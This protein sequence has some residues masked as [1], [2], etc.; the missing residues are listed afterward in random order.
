V[1]VGKWDSTCRSVNT[2]Q[3]SLGPMGGEKDKELRIGKMA[4][5][6]K[7]REEGILTWERPVSFLQA[8]SRLPR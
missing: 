4:N 6:N 3:V 5:V 8:C 7:G 2:R 1:G